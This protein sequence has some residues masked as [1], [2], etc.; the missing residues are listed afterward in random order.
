MNQKDVIAKREEPTF[1]GRSSIPTQRMGDAYHYTGDPLKH[2]SAVYHAGS[3]AR[4][5]QKRT[6]LGNGLIRVED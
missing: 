2:T 5:G 6:A 3:N 1:V 4:H